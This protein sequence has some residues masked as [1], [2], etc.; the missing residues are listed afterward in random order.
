MDCRICH[1][2]LVEGAV[3][4]GGCGSSTTVDPESWR[5]AVSRD[6]RLSDTTVLRPRRRIASEP[7]V[8]EHGVPVTSVRLPDTRATSHPDAIPEAAPDS[9]G[10]DEQ[11]GHIPSDGASDAGSA[12]ASESRSDQSPSTRWWK[13]RAATRGSDGG[14]ARSAESKPVRL[15]FSTGE[16]ATVTGPALIGRRPLAQVGESIE[17][18]IAVVDPQR[19]VSKTHLEVGQ[20][21]GELWVCDRFSVNGTVITD[22]EGIIRTLEPGRRYL[23]RS[24][25]TVVF[26]EQS[27]TID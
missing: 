13:R 14:S 16:V 1:V 12:R 8:H 24:G 6:S 18:L 2:V 21:E 10:G 27:L 11:P 3:F 25:A 17:H 9:A 4:C 7:P 19:T 23:V 5:H 15:R 22:A 20:H 26:G